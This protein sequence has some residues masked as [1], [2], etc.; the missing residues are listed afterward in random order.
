MSWASI[1]LAGWGRTSRGAMTACRPERVSEIRERMGE[2]VPGAGLIG[3]GAGRAYGDA[4]LN[5]GGRVMLMRRLD[6]MLAFDPETGLLETEPGVSFADLLAAFLPRGWL[7]AATPGTA[8]ATLGGAVA[9]DVHGKNHDRMGSFGDHLAWIDLMLPSGEVARVTE[10]GDP[11]LFR[12]TIGGLGL[13]GVVVG[14]GLKLMRVP[15]GAVRVRERR[16]RDLDAF[17]A[18]LNEVRTRS[19]YSVGWIDGLARG[20]ALGRG[21]LEE[22]EPEPAAELPAR[23]TRQLSVPVDLPGF[24]LNGA[25][26]GL[27]NAAYFRRVPEGGRDRLMP[28]ARFLYPL[29]SIGQ[30]NR[31]Y[32]RGGFYQFQ[33]VLPD[34]TAPVGLR[35]MLEEISE[36]G[37]ASFLAVLKTL[38]GEGRGFLSF[39][40]RGFTLA[41]DFPRR[42]GVEDLLARLERLTLDHGGRIY[43]AKDAALSPEGFRRMYTRHPE[44]EAVLE[45]VDPERRLNSDMA[46]RLKIR[47]RAP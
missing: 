20:G 40:M 21:I 31:I 5:A 34:A 2:A 42:P 18:A 8:F 47:E 10:G 29:D 6:R 30:W 12:A 13:T 11:A 24:V 1:E 19:A 17:L 44:F 41:L 26:V 4:A 23:R 45:R 16:C 46:R 25:T 7:A 14:L 3:H 28:Y 37:R 22:A 9:N 39:P 35:R 36:T 43:L 15:S 33:C 27:F 38:G 32:G